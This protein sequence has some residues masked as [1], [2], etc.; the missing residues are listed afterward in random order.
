MVVEGHLVQ[1][2]GS[3]PPLSWIEVVVTFIPTVVGIVALWRLH[4]GWGGRA[5]SLVV[6]APWTEFLVRISYALMPFTV[7]MFLMAFGGGTCARLA[8]DLPADWL[9][10]VGLV[11]FVAGL[12]CMGWGAREF[13]TP[14]QWR[15]RPPWVAE[16]E[17]RSKGSA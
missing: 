12:V 4:S 9:R 5:Y 7:G 8:Y 17:A 3:A 11:A 6:G 2:A 14:R 1:S 13:F 15:R 16:Y 10:I